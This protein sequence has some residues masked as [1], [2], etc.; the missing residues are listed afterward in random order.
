MFTR[1][2]FNN[3]LKDLNIITSFQSI[4][5]FKVNF[6]LTDC[7]FVVRSFNF[8]T[9]VCQYIYDFTSCVSSEVSWCKVKITTF[10]IHFKC[11]FIIFIKFEKEELWF[12]SKVKALEAQFF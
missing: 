3:K 1:N 4:G 10:I 8:K 7:Y 2:C 12:R 6:V 9:K 5:I 11:W